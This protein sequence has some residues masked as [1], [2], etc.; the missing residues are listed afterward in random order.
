MTET[1]HKETAAIIEPENE[2]ETIAC[3]E[4]EAHQEEEK[5]ASLDRKPEAA[6][7]YEVAAENSSDTGRRTEEE[8][9]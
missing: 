2:V 4:M 8:K 1:S 7:E 6:E 5:P 9:A 3:Q